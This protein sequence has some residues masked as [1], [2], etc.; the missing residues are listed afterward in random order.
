MFYVLYQ[1]NKKIYMYLL[2]IDQRV[3]SKLLSQGI[4]AHAKSQVPVPTIT[5]V[6]ILR[7]FKNKF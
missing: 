3:T 5:T 1:I 7:Y 6:C 4:L 2:V